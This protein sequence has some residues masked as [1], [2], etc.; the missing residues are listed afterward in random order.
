MLASLDVFTAPPEVVA[1]LRLE[2]GI[3]LHVAGQP[4]EAGELLESALTLA[5]HYQLAETL[6]RGLSYKANLL[7]MNGR[8]EEARALYEA[9]ISV[10]GRHGF[11]HV[12]MYAECTFADLCMTRD[13]AGAEEHARASLDL[14][15]RSGLR[16]SETFAASNLMYVLTMAGRFEEVHQLETELLQAGGDERPGADEIHFRVACLEAL[17]GA[18]V[19]ARE[20]LAIC[21]TWAESDDVQFRTMYAAAEAAISLADGDSHGALASARVSVDEAMR[22][23]LGVAHES[24]RLAFPIALEAAI[25]PGYL[26]EADRI[27]ELLTARPPGE[28]PPFLRAQVSRAKALLAGARG[29]NEDVEENL[30]A[31]ETTCRQLGYPYWTARAQLDRAE[32]LKG[33]DRPDE[34]TRLAVEAA[35]TFDTLGTVPLLIRA[36]TLLEPEMAR[37]S[38]A[39]GERVVAQSYPSLSDHP[40]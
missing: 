6:A 4:D 38:R 21:R 37:E 34:S 25:D 9:A 20:H 10:S 15:Q 23:G 1:E 8:A 30:V 33:Q 5:Q 18:A 2:L 40:A 11:T 27:V 32:W 29:E 35:A 22:G 13:L 26:G 17:R 14:A 39:D 19:A 28:V 31:A 12:E 7:S 36:R 24:V 16:W 3:I